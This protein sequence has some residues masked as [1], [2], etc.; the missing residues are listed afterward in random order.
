VELF[1]GAT[2]FVASTEAAWLAAG[3]SALYT[4]A[5]QV[6]HCLAGAGAALFA[7][8]ASA[9]PFGAVS[10][11]V[12]CSCLCSILAGAALFTAV[13][14]AAL[15]HLSGG[16]SDWVGTYVGV[17]AVAPLDGVGVLLRRQL[18]C[19]ILINVIMHFLSMSMQYACVVYIVGGFVD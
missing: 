17:V 10:S 15:L 1:A 13:A 12:S 18:V 2:W 8:G 14:S 3:A 19:C 9:A 11:I 4:A 7:A 5:G 16:F 6:R